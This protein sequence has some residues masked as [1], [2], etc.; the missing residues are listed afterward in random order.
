MFLIHL[1]ATLLTL[2]PI[3]FPGPSP[4][5][6]DRI[7]DRDRDLL[8][9]SVQELI[10]IPSIAGE[11][12]PGAPF[13]PG[14][15]G[16]LTGA[17]GIAE[18]LGF[19]PTNLG[20]YAGF[21]EFGSGDEYVGILGHVD[22]VPEGEDWTHPPFGGEI[23]G[24]KIYGRGALDD[25][26]PA[27]AALF[28][29]RAVMESGL[30]LSR[31]VRVIF[32]A[33]E[34]T[35]VE[36]IAHYLSMERPPVS[37]FTPDADFPVVFAEKGILWIELQRNFS[38]S[39]AE[40][41]VK[42]IE[43]GSAPNM[44]PDRAT[45]ELLAAHPE[46]VIANCGEF[47]RQTGFPLEARLERGCVIVTA[48]GQ[49]A[50]ASTP[51]K[52]RNAIMFLLGFLASQKL[53][54][55]A[56]TDAIRLFSRAIGCELNGR[57]FGIEIS[58]APSGSLTLNAGRI[59]ATESTFRLTLDIRYPVTSDKTD[60]VNRIRSTLRASGFSGKILE[61]QPP[62][63]HPEDSALVRTLATVYREQ[64]GIM[65]PPV[66]IGG[67]TYARSLPNIVAFGPCRPGQDPPIHRQ[68]ECIA[69]D[70]LVAMAKIYAHAIYELAK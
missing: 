32:G 11:P 15:R 18:R 39:S 55:G 40:T 63:H 17:L 45:A 46:I 23:H 26:G 9:A 59:E 28:G 54:P 66:A 22:V 67:G 49:S 33:D 42:K 36:D 64:T 61:H 65:A 48:R 8:V 29:A 38:T 7:V 69:I 27:L 44:V 24:G 14:P 2:L 12:E 50:H 6:L 35:G 70:E 53:S 68:D 58:D 4:K 56:M 60:V 5:M 41:L 13:G 51:E 16:A 3:S 10:R 20:N 30:P 52:G 43:G 1:P 34:E 21:A 19:S 57:S 25:K 47:V 31:R 62:L 37:G